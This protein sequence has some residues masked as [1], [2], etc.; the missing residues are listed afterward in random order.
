[1]ENNNSNRK[2]EETNNNKYKYQFF[3]RNSELDNYHKNISDKTS[4]LWNHY[5]S[6]DNTINSFKYD[7]LYF[8]EKEKKFLN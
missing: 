1:M 5:L 3:S 4:S 2:S 6:K 7:K 8:Y